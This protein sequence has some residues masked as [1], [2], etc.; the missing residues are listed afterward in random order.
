MDLSVS[1]QY[2]VARSSAFSVNSPGPAWLN[3]MA[4][5]TLSAVRFIGIRV[6]AGSLIARITTT[7]GALQLVPLSDLWILHNPLAGTE[8]TTLEVQGT[9]NIEMLI[10]GDS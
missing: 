10:A 6:N 1:R 3:L 7:A 4:G 2:Q 8:I 9:A 5:I